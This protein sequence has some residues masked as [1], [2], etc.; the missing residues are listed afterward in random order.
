MTTP[1][2][3]AAATKI[4]FNVQKGGNVAKTLAALKALG[5]MR[6][7][8]DAPI[9]QGDYAPYFP[10]MAAGG[11]KF[12]IGVNGWEGQA[13][14][15][16][17]LGFI[18]Q[19]VT[20]YP[21]CVEYLAGPN[22]VNNNPQQWE[23]GN[24]VFTDTKDGNVSAHTAAMAVQDYIVATVAAD[25]ILMGI[26]VLNYTDETPPTAR[27]GSIPDI[28]VYDNSTSNGPLGWWIDSDGLA[29]L[30]KTNPSM[31]RFAISETGTANSNP[32]LFAAYV[33]QAI[34]SAYEIGAEVAY[35]YAV[36]DYNGQT[37]GMFDGSWNAKP[38]V[39]AVSSLLSLLSDTGAT[40]LTFTPKV[41]TP[42]L[43][44]PHNLVRQTLIAKSDGTFLW[45]WWY[46]NPQAAVTLGYGMPQAGKWAMVFGG[47]APVSMGAWSA[48][49]SDTWKSYTGDL[50]V[51][52]IQPS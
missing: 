41:I 3:R 27:A 30:Q 17:Q 8:C 22:E 46:W 18:R 14:V 6:A 9:S 23:I 7:R 15:D 29:K 28:H 38:V 19:L 39:A 40:A 36:N 20:A 47:S 10:G 37:Y 49:A 5:S 2:R 35:L 42:A 26:P 48:K 25:P 32:A 16:T 4:G 12:C 43:T 50:T 44:D 21:G 31:T 45:A 1:I 33:C 34:M 52:H 24:I 11:A 51:L 13:M